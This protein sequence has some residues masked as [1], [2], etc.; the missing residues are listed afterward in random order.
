MEFHR[1]IQGDE[2]IQ[3]LG[4]DLQMLARKVFP[5]MEGRVFD[6]MFYQALHPRWQRKL[7]APKPEETF[8]QLFKRARILKQHER[9]FTA[10]AAS[11][12]EASSKRAK[13]AVSPV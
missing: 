9:Q 10:S 8:G 4:M 1:R 3:E 6:R 11:R 5:S 7:S 12:R 2:T 13:P